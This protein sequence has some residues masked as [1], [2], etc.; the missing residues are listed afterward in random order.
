MQ[1]PNRPKPTLVDAYEGYYGTLS[2]FRKITVRFWKSRS[3]MYTNISLLCS[4]FPTHILASSDNGFMNEFQI[5]SIEECYKF[6]KIWVNMEFYM[7]NW[8]Y[9][10]YYIGKDLV[11]INKLDF[12]IRNLLKGVE[13]PEIKQLDYSAEIK[14]LRGKWVNEKLLYNIVKSLFPNY[15]VLFHFRAEWLENLELDIF[16]KEISVGIEYQ[17]IQHYEA[18]KHWS[19]EKGL[20]HRQYNDMRKKTLC[21]NMG[22]KILYFDYTENISLS[23]VEK[24]ITNFLYHSSL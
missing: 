7:R 9:C 24:K 1:V 5:N 14:V 15:T 18:I 23:Y 6:Y 10:E 13:Y 12:Y 20:K 21:Q 16:I 11:Y 17:G 4:I 3:K 2:E 19:G 8:K 22:V